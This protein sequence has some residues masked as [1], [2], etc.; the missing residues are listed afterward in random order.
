MG[1]RITFSVKSSSKLADLF[2]GGYSAAAAAAAIRI[3]K[4]NKDFELPAFYIKI[5]NASPPKILHTYSWFIFYTIL[6][7]ATGK[8]S[9]G[10]RFPRFVNSSVL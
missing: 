10:S 8:R 6:I 3:Q 9:E 5:R 7:S 4:E 2:E 1:L